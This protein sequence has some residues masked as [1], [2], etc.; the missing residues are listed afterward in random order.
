[1]TKTPQEAQSQSGVASPEPASASATAGVATTP[2]PAASPIT[3][4]PDSETFADDLQFL[5]KHTS[6]VVLGD[7]F[8]GPAVAV[9]PEYQGRV[10]TSS[11][12]GGKGKSFGFINRKVVAAR[13]IQPHITVFGGEDRFWLGPEGGQFGLYFPPGAPY[14]FEHWQ[15]P[16][17]IDWGAWQITQRSAQWIRFV[18]DM[19]LKNHLGTE[20]RVHVDRRVGLLSAKELA[21]HLGSPL[22]EGAAAVGYESENTITNTGTAAWTKKAGLV[23]VWILGMFQPSPTTT[24]VLPFKPGPEKTLGK[25]VNDTY[26]G[27]I[28]SERLRTGK[29]VLFFSGDGKERG[30]IG[31]PAPRALPIAGS[32]DA[33]NSVLTL[34]QY[35]LP[36]GGAYVNSMWEEQKAPYGGDVVNSYNDGPPAPGKEPLGPFYELETSS[37]GAELTPGKSLT[38]VHRT[39]HVQGPAASLDAIAKQQLGVTIA[40][41]TQPSPTPAPPSP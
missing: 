14:D 30:K 1:M 17:P 16:E 36:K 12:L 38:H 2:P 18:K 19:V 26:F 41:I 8:D 6:V 32:Y 29:S 11:A 15:V 39:I 24:V 37:P 10:M 34:V 20:L 3:P 13:S 9:A 5:R 28:P 4:S 22:P 40:E 21:D 33:T 31:I 23:S 35:T 7:E 25:I 27:K